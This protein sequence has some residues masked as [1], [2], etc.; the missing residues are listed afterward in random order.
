MSF[1]DELLDEKT[2]N[3][4]IEQGTPE[5]DAVRVG[6]FTSSE[7]WR[8]MVD[9]KSN[10]DKEAGKLSETSMTY[11]NEKVAEVMT[12]QCK[13]QGYAFPLVWGTEKEPEAIEYF[14]NK[15]GFTHERVGFF[16]FSDHAGGSPD[17]I[18]NNM[19]ILEV[20]CPY[21]SKVQI[22]Y[23][24]LTDQYDLKRHFRE[25]YWQCQC[26]LLF[27][28]FDVCH[29]VTY[30]PRMKDDKHMMTHLIINKDEKDHLLIVAKL[31]KAVEEKLKLLSLLK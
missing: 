24:M 20:K 31:E 4:W 26:N 6:R 21:D 10:A 28:G 16:S 18:I 8:L 9:P 12:G 15:T 13:P 19:E 29:F 23:L 14:C 7:N 25:Y 27:T 1:L 2:A 11:V 30:D 22:E 5:W 3:R 17:G